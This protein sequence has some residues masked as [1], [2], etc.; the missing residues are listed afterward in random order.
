M[1]QFK[2]NPKQCQGFATLAKNQPE[3][4]AGH[5]LSSAWSDLARTLIFARALI[6]NWNTKKIKPDRKSAIADFLSGLK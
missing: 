3:Q 6:F 2:R 1:F 5:K 4:I